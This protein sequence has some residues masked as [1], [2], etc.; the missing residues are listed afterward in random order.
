MKYNQWLTEWLENFV[1]PT[2]KQR[3]YERYTDIINQHIIGELGDYE[4]NMLTPLV[5]QHFTMRLLKSGNLIT[6]KGLSTSYVNTIV[7]VIQ[8]SLRTAYAAGQLD[9]YCADKIKRPKNVEKKVVCFT[10]VEQKKIEDFVLN[11][12]KPRLFGIVIC[13]YTGVRV[14]ELL[15]LEWTDVDFERGT[16]CVDKCVRD[17]FD[18]G[19]MLRMSDSPKTAQSIRLIPLPKQL[20]PW[21]KTMY[22]QS[23]S[24]YVIESSMGEPVYVR[25]YQRSFERC[26]NKLNIPHRGF[27]ALRHTFATRALE[28]GM[29]IKTLAEILGHKNASVTLSRYVHSMLSH[30][31]E[32]MNNLGKIF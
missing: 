31:R 19:K 12:G 11:S 21:L 13:L 9:E 32:M 8:N 3:T 14:G 15:A 10:D 6:G 5:L 24:K 4:M 23:T 1:K 27:H 28:C 18:E 25:A 29:D 2:A 30:K 20:K 7:T 16:I 22:R 26:L 17:K